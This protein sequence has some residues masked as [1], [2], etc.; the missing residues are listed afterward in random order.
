[1][2]EWSLYKHTVPN[3]KV[4]IGITVQKPEKR[5][6][7]GKGYKSNQY[8]YNAICKYG[9]EN[10]KH[11]IVCILETKDEACTEEKKQIKKY[12][13]N[14]PNYGYNLTDGGEHYEFTP[15]VV[16]RL[17]HS[18]KLTDAQREE[19]KIRGRIAYEK[20]LKGRKN[21]P[22][23]IKKMAESKRNKKQSQDT[24][25]K[26]RNS[27]EKTFQ[28]KGGFSEEHKKKISEALKGRTYSDETL[29]KMRQAKRP[30]KNGRSRR[31]QQLKD[32]D[33]IA[34]YCSTREAM[35]ITG[36]DYS[37]IVRACTKKRLKHAGGFEWQ[38]VDPP[39]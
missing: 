20:F 23:Q 6:N 15:N 4:Y 1:M 10:I 5:W 27:W 32:G 33:I 25:Q 14:D 16:E 29:E 24:I 13:A 2:E 21:T 31:V 28:E 3:G 12:K 30:E 39:K 36:I 19:L 22:E 8:F 9:W 38:Y 7:N 37:S 34:E 18:K 17:K 26:R 35:R 11:E